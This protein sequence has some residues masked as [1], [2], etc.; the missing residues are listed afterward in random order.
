[1]K[2]V[3]FVEAVGHRGLSYLIPGEHASIR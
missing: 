2:D 1:V 3:V